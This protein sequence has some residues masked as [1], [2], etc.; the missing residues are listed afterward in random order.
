LPDR[1]VWAIGR[2]SGDRIIIPKGQVLEG[3]ERQ[4]VQRIR[5]GDGWAAMSDVIA[6]KDHL[7]VSDSFTLPTPAGQTRFRLAARLTNVGWPPGT[8][9]LNQR[10]Y[11]RAWLTDDPSAVEVDLAPGTSAAN[12][13]P[14]IW[15]IVGTG[16]PLTVQTAGERWA[17][18]RRNARQGLNRLTQIATLVLIG[19]IVST[20]LA[21]WASVRQRRVTIAGDRIQGFGL[22]QLWSSLLA[23]AAM[24]LGFG[25]AIGATFGLGGQF[26]LTRWLRL[27]TGFPTEYGP[28]ILLAVLLFLI[29][30]AAA[31]V[32]IAVPGYF[33]AR[34][35]MRVRFAAQD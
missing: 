12:E 18:L 14:R 34:T 5:A 24:L 6:A 23:E 30:A 10:D 31:L 32:V 15:R 7:H 27:T 35:P 13:L 29:V 2:P 19:A 20:A 22:L 21:M 8:I 11:A 33:A 4:A 9:I 26:L 17:L 25:S 16:S 1:R 28:A 3:D